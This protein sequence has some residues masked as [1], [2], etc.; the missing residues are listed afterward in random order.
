MKVIRARLSFVRPWVSAN[1]KKERALVR[2]VKCSESVRVARILA[3]SGWVMIRLT[4]LLEVFLRLFFGRVGLAASL[5]IVSPRPEKPIAGPP[6]PAIPAG[7][8]ALPGGNP[9]VKLEAGGSIPC[10]ASGASRRTPGAGEI[11]E[12]AELGSDNFVFLRGYRKLTVDTR[13][14]G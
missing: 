10:E 11:A 13:G 8:P 7:G 2:K 6:I 3:R 4:K 14:V 1:Q 12:S 9:P 5:P